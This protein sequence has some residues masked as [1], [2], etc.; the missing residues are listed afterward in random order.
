ME[1]HAMEVTLIAR[2][3][4]RLK[5]L[6]ENW[7]AIQDR[8]DEL[9]RMETGEKTSKQGSAC[10]VSA[11]DKDAHLDDVQDLGELVRQRNAESKRSESPDKD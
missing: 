6:W 8:E 11:Q 1:I 7:S 4:T 3:K 10:D 2:L 5:K 9:W